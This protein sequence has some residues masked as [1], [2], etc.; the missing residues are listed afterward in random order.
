MRGGMGVHESEEAG[1]ERKKKTMGKTY[2]EVGRRNIYI[3][4]Y[5]YIKRQKKL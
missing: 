1:G 5:I 4:I 3:Y 2:G